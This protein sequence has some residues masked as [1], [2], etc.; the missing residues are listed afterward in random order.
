MLPARRTWR[1]FRELSARM[2]AP[3][4]IGTLVVLVLAVLLWPSA[5]GVPA[6]W[7]QLPVTEMTSIYPPGG[8]Q[9]AQVEVTVGGAELEDLRALVISHPGI[10]AQQKMTEPSEFQP[11]PRK[12]NNQFVVS[13]AADVPPGIYEARV[14]GRFGASNPRA[15]VVGTLDEVLDD[16][17][18]KQLSTAR[19]VPVGT[20]VNGRVDASSQDYYKLSLK[21]GERVLIDCRAQRIDSKMDPA[22]VLYDASGREIL[23]NRDMNGADPMLDFTAP[24]D[25]DYTVGVFDF[26]YGGGNDH[27]Y[28]LAIHAAPHL[29]FVLP[30]AGLP[31][32]NDSYTIYGR[33]LPGG[34]PV[35]G[36]ELNG[37][38]L[39]QVTVNIALPSDDSQLDVGS[40]AFPRMAAIDAVSYQLD[41]SNP[42]AVGL[43]SAPVV[44]EKEPN[45]QP[46]QAQL[47]TIPGEYAGQFYPQRDQDW[48]QF[49]A[50]QG[51][52]YWIDVI[53]QRAGPDCDPYFT[54]QQ[55][56]VNEQGVETV[57]DIAQA[58][59][60]ADRAARIGS[61]FDTST[62]DPSYRF[63]VPADGMYR[64]MIR[65]QFGSSTAD[66][67]LVY[68]L[69]ITPEEPDF[70]LVVFPEQIKVANANQVLL[71]SPVVRQ[72]GTTLLR[73]EA[74]RWDGF[75][76][77]IEVGVEGLPAGVT[78]QGA[79]LSGGVNT[80]WLVFAAEENAAAWQGPI[81]VVGKAQINGQEVIRRARLGSVVWPTA[82]RT[83]D[84]PS[85]RMTQDVMLS[86]IDAERAVGQVRVGDGSV[87]ETS[88]GGKLEVPITVA[89]YGEFKENLKLVATGMPNEIKPADVDIAGDK[90]EGKLTIAISN[91]NAKPGA[92][93]FY[94]RADTKYAKWERNPEAV[95]SAEAEQKRLEGIV[96]QVNEEVKTSTAARDESVK[97]AQ[98]AATAMTAA[99]QAK[100]AAD[101][102]LQQAQ[103]AEKQATDKLAAA[104]E[105]AAKD[106]ANE[107]LAAAVTAAKQAADEAAAK[108]KAAQETAAAKDKEL[109]TAA[110]AVKTAEAAKAQAEQAL[111]DL[112][113]KAKRAVAAKAAADKALDDAKKANAAKDMNI[114]LVSTPIRLNILPSPVQLSSAESVTAQLEAK[115]EI[116]VKVQRGYGFEDQVEITLQ[117]PAGT[118]GFTAAKLTIPKDQSEGKLE[119]T[120]AKNAPVGRHTFALKGQ[121]KFNNVT[122][123]SAAEV[124]VQVEPAAEAK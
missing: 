34:K 54:L 8:K 11:E 56:T 113:E 60:P 96:G 67:R 66:P 82:N 53:A 1:I 27:F 64:V 105:A 5:A 47:I 19:S 101:Q 12:V 25:G 121:V 102:A 79:I 42:L 89:R 68:R 74:L 4:V 49:Q 69:R 40:L 3:G 88:R 107:A 87:L 43:A 58:D 108:T 84:L 73:L 95:K 38:P 46:A 114:A 21:A 119:L 97:Q 115:V 41:K 91:A 33:N 100:T 29:D 7:A 36:M 37:A 93:T 18:N 23:R 61:D 123:D 48:V 124:V 98:A 24:A 63:V 57:R 81:Q 30:P 70:R 104:T 16:G 44:L 99:Q 26:L 78:C 86:V 52:V 120:V 9:G 109:A 65:D 32:S 55:V 10:T 75:D 45:D 2:P 35:A 20:L 106:A 90:T 77:T 14:V 59:D 111:K 72:G 116:P 92:Y 13:I 31:G 80:A 62:D 118:T 76:G 83:A 22:L 103:A 39:E 15:F 94:L 6:A 85:F 28:R 117:P 50:K 51:E 112:Q 110:E 17:A 122:C 71:Y